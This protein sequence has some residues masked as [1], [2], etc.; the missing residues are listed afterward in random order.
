[1]Q[2]KQR[3]NSPAEPHLY[4]VMLD[5]GGKNCLVIG[6]GKVAERKVF[7]LLKTGACIKVISPSLTERLKKEK[8]KGT[9]THINR[10]YRGTDLKG[11]FLVISATDSYEENKKIAQDCKDIPVNV[12]DTPSLCNFIVP[13]VFRRGPLVIAISTSGTSPAMAKAIRKELEALYPTRFGPYLKS[14]KKMRS[15]AVSNIEDRRQRAKLLKSLASQKVIDQ[16]RGSA[17]Q[18]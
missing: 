11:A 17:T 12:V 8:S 10:R 16:L 4:P 13:S 5:L 6:G 18:K 7:G 9:L 3:K 1:M 14:L 15:K 2:K